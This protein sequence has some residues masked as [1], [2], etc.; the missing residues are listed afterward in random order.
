MLETEN[1]GV[2]P[3]NPKALSAALPCLSLQRV[4]GFRKVFT[5]FHISL[6]LN[7]KR[8]VLCQCGV[9]YLV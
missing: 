7:F 2:F 6:T 4:S 3:L 8:I 5:L 1:F 9:H